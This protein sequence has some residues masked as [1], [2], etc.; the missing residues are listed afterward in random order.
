VTKWND[1]SNQY[2][3]SECVSYGIFEVSQDTIM[4]EESQH[5]FSL[6][7]VRMYHDPLDETMT[8]SRYDNIGIWGADG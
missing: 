2:D 6:K 4:V 7:I 1:A 5:Y 3:I 8:E